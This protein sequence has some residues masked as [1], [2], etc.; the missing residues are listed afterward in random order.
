MEFHPRKWKGP[1][2]FRPLPALCAE[3]KLLYKFGLP[4]PCPAVFV[5]EV[6]LS[7]PLGFVPAPH[8]GLPTWRQLASPTLCAGGRV[9][10]FS[11]CFAAS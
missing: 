4:L 10:L 1:W 2:E 11:S 8:S 5:E 7:E 6:L 3:G 9:G